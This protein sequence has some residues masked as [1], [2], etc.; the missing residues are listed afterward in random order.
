M[1]LI[2]WT[3]FNWGLNQVW[4]WGCLSYFGGC[5][6]YLKLNA[7]IVAFSSTPAFLSGFQYHE[8]GYPFVFSG[9]IWSCGYCFVVVT[10]IFVIPRM[11]CFGTAWH[12]NIGLWYISGFLS[13]TLIFS[14][15]LLH[16]LTGEDHA[17]FELGAISVVI[18]PGFIV[19]FNSNFKGEKSLPLSHCLIWTVG[20]M[21][22][23]VYA[24]ESVFSLANA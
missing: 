7:G 9:Q 4:Y 18:T 14:A 12:L 13:S 15:S 17:E 20:F 24:F 6:F 16:E 5:S 19:P 11:W 10:V 1:T 21:R 3:H 8:M 23:R 2:F 22:E